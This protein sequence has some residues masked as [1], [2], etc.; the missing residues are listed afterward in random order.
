MLMTLSLKAVPI[1]NPGAG[2][3]G[4][5]LAPQG[6]HPHTFVASIIHLVFIP[7]LKL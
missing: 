3:A 5:S 1:S 6:A 4:S 2:F 7:D